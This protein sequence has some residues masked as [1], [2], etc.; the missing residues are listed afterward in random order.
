M[1]LLLTSAGFTNE[2][3]IQA[4]KDLTDKPLNELKL[5]FI[6]TAANVEIGGKEW[7]I[8]DLH[9]CANLGLKQI[10]IVDISALSNTVFL[11]RIV[12]SDII[13]FGGGNT[14]YLMTWIEKSGLKK[15]LP[16]LLKTRI[17]VGL[18]AGSMIASKWWSCEYDTRYY[19][20]PQGPKKYDCLGMVDFHIIPH[21]YPS[22]F[23][24]IT[25]ENMEKLSK[26]F[27]EPLFALDDNSA[28]KY[29]DGKIEIVSE[30][31]WKR[32]N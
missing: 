17:Y 21:L 13:F 1:R 10:D 30:G 3:I 4:L 6:P 26:E 32:F 15:E 28:L 29:V 24:K 23:P 12:D 9:R 18:S 22:D 11:P 31:V 7:L 16:E 19:D 5:V 27:K 14:H 2:K 8:D 20:E 25:L